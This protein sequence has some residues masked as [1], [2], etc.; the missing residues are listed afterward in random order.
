MSGGGPGGGPGGQPEGAETESRSPQD[1]YEQQSDD[2]SG[3]YVLCFILVIAA[4]VWYMPKRLGG[5]RG[6]ICNRMYPANALREFVLFWRPVATLDR[7]V[8]RTHPAP[9][10]PY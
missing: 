7:A 10:T 6:G 3:F 4:L 8:T 9:A 5:P 1:F 2:D